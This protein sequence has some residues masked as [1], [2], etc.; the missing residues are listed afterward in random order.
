MV[1]NARPGD[2]GKRVQ[3][4]TSMTVSDLPA[5]DL[6]EVR[7]RPDYAA[8]FVGTP[9][10]SV[11]IGTYNR[12]RILCERTLP[13]VI[14]QTYPNW[15]AVIVGDACTDDTA[16]RI[17]ALDDPRIR[18]YNRPVR[19]PYPADPIDFHLVA[20]VFPANEGLDLARGAW[21]APLDDDDEF[22]PDH[23]QT[24]LGAAIAERAEFVYGQMRVIIE[25]SDAQTWFGTWP[26]AFGDFGLQSAVY[27]A[28]LKGF[29]YDI[30][31]YRHGEP[32][33]WNLTRRM[34][35]AGVRFHYVQ[36]AVGVYHVRVAEAAHWESV[37]QVRGRLP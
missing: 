6:A 15:E 35:A 11:R 37:A 34:I 17:A 13:S 7:T 18:F 25:Q 16:A 26:P 9:L 33:D 20:G 19:G 27:H 8:A 30:N 4:V 36:R 5:P 3:R 12:A 31:A 1:D 23:I 14:A 2:S 28:H 10:V 29:R 32:D 21:I 24:L 22:S